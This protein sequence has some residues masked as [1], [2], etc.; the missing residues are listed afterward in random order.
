MPRTWKLTVASAPVPSTKE[1]TVTCKLW[2]S[3]V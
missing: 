1:W 2:L 3:E